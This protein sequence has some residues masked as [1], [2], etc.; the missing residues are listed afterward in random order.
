MIFL[1]MAVW[2][3]GTVR[4]GEKMLFENNKIDNKE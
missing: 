3:G 4:V 2:Y 1:W